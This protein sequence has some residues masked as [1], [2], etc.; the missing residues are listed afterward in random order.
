MKIRK[1][2]CFVAISPKHEGSNVYLPSGI[3]TIPVYEKSEYATFDGWER[4]EIVE[5]TLTYKERK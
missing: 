2:K 1:I 4:N 5:C 3:N